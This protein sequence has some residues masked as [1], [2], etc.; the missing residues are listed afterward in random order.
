MFSAYYFLYATLGILLIAYIPAIIAANKERSFSKWYVYG[1]VLFPVA[2][3][4]SL[5]LK[6]PIHRANIFIHDKEN[7]TKRKRK[8]YLLVPK[9][10][11]KISVS[12]KYL[13]MVF[14]SKFIFGAFVA[15][16]VFAI[17]RTI[18]HGTETLM[19]AC[20]VFAILFS[21][22]LSIVEICRLSKFPYLA[23]EITKRA[24]IMI[25]YS[26]ICS[27]PLYLIKTYIADPMLSEKHKDLAMFLF[28]LVASGVFI[29]LLLRR[30]RV[31]YS[32]FNKFR[33]YCVLS[34]CAYA[35]VAALALVFMASNF[36]EII[37][38]VAMPSQLFNVT[39]L[40][41]VKVIGNLSYIY[42]SAFVH[43]FVE[44]MI[45]VSGL[46]CWKFKKK[47]REFRVE[48]RSKAFR[49]S[50]KRILRRHILR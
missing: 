31:F 20:A 44:V 23:D 41:D 26:T 3:I 12:V 33:D 34:V 47:E 25:A 15:F 27:L 40:S 16:S 6:K 32:V 10:K 21:V 9:E 37:Y 5:I 43:L 1:A 11:R 7:P 18:V 42:S 14:F 8:T 17:F 4:H 28:T 36:R 24:L 45:I 29:A 49:M 38:A 19:Q 35:M 22:M 39:Y 13:Y 30:Q 50:R 46:L 48:Y 2:F